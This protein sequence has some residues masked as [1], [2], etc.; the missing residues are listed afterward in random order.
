MVPAPFPT[1]ALKRAPNLKVADTHSFSQH[2]EVIRGRGERTISNAEVSFPPPLMKL[3]LAKDN[4]CPNPF[5]SLAGAAGGRPINPKFDALSPKSRAFLPKQ[6][7]K[8]L[9][10]LLTNHH[11]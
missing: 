1:T 8:N 9:Q 5:I 6:L 4:G 2:P 7:R 10:N 11:G 3:L